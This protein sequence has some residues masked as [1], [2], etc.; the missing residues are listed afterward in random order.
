VRA[1][2][3]A[4][5]LLLA[6]CSDGGPRPL[7][8]SEADRLAVMRF[9]GYQDRMVGFTGTIPGATGAIAVQGRLDFVAHIGY[10]TMRAN[11]STRVLQWSPSTL[12]VLSEPAT[13]ASDPPPAGEWQ[14]RALRP[15]GSELDAPLEVLLALGRD[16]P[17]NAQLLR[18]GS[19]RWLRSDTVRDKPVDVFAGPAES[20]RLRYWVDADARLLHLEAWF[21]NAGDAA[22]FDF[23]PGGKPITALPQLS[24][25]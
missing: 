4:T 18:Q 11:G 2:V 9:V 3:F 19:A 22:V 12:A 13:V 10:G 25:S 15:V 1:L 8:E 17:D 23:T 24:A 7:T 5:V 20:S 16:R 21:G 6:A 14:L